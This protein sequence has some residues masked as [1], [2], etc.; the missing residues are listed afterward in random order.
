MSDAPKI[1]I[2]INGEVLLPQAEA[3]KL[4]RQGSKVWNA[5]A[6]SLDAQKVRVEFSGY[7]FTNDQ[8][9]FSHFIFPGVVEFS[10]CQFSNANF[11]DAIFSGG[12]A[13][14]IKAKFFGKSTSFKRAQF[15]GGDAFFINA[16]FCDGDVGFGNAIFSGGDALFQTARFEFGAYFH[17]AEFKHD[18]IF[19]IVNFEHVVVFKDAI[20]SC[21]PDFR[22]SNIKVHFSLHGMIIDFSSELEDIYFRGAW[23]KKV[24]DRD[25]ADKLR[26]LKELAGLAKDHEREQEFFALELQAKRFHETTHFWSLVLS[27]FYQFFSDFG[28]SFLRP[29]GLLSFIWAFWGFGFALFSGLNF[30]TLLAGLRL[31]GAVIMPFSATVS[32]AFESTKSV[33]Y[34]NLG[35]LNLLFD[36]IVII[37]GLL[38]LTCVFLIG[39]ALRNRFRI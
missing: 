1:E 27:V 24:T 10:T 36:G 15:S 30:A 28:R 39:L 26:R 17:E 35:K 20:F 19:S 21:V 31:S 37:E 23:W 12:P 8:I 29:L 6:E 18:A 33:L 7:D 25:I 2:D 34:P 3:L 9:D 32:A 13:I 11:T 14:F 22:Y 16:E 5:W 38:S 4:A